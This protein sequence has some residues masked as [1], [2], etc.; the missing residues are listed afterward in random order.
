MQRRQ[1]L[2]G[3]GG[4]SGQGLVEVALSLTVLFMVMFGVFEFGRYY[5][6]RLTLRHV[7]RE[8]ARFA[9][10][11]NVLTDSLGVPM[12]R[13]ASIQQLILASNR[14]LG[15]GIDPADITLTPPDGGSPGGIVQVDVRYRYGIVLPLL[16]A[17]FPDGGV[18]IRISTVM[19]N[20]RF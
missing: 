10:T 15:L 20:E 12:S 9:V 5:W 14:T 13:E 11:G 16:S 18:I 1:R 4:E 8:S 17:A 19:K 7:V 2:R 3:P 6:T